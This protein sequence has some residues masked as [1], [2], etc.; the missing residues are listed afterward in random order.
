MGEAGADMTRGAGVA[1]VRFT[2]DTSFGD[3]R[4]EER[5]AEI[6]A[7]ER[8]IAEAAAEGRERGLAEGRAE[9]LAGI[10]AQASALL[11]RIA[12]EA[13][14]LFEARAAIERGM[15][16]ETA[17]LAHMMASRLAPA[18]M[19]RHPLAEI[20]ALVAECLDGCR[21]EP[22]LVLRVHESL[23]DAMKARIEP[24]AAAANFAGDIVLMED[25]ALGPHDCR[26]EWPDGGAERDMAAI[27][28]AMDAAIARFVAH[29][30]EDMPGDGNDGQ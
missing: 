30:D 18:L 10:E 9:A 25:P 6:A 23:L 21:R 8:R 13:V 7:L 16:R 15:E 28:A 24:L 4:E 3:E 1:P 20:E 29:D 11:E 2:F 22:R 27:R 5:D 17:R 12:G 14:R 19:Q 26:L